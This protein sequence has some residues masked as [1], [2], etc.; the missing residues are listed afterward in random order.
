MTGH[1]IHGTSFEFESF[2]TT[3]PTCSASMMS[4]DKKPKLHRI[5]EK[6]K[7]FLTPRDEHY[8]RQF[9]RLFVDYLN[10]DE[11]LI[12]S[13]NCLY[14][15]PERKTPL[16]GRLFVSSMS[17]AFNSSSAPSRFVLPFDN[18]FRINKEQQK[19]ATKANGIR[20]V[21]DD[22]VTC[23]FG[24]FSSCDKAYSVILHQWKIKH[25][26]VDDR[27]VG[28]QMSK[29]KMNIEMG[30]NQTT[31]ESHAVPTDTASQTSHNTDDTSQSCEPANCECTDHKGHNL[32]DAI[33]PLSA[34]QMFQFLFTDN[35]NMREFLK[36]A[37]RTDVNYETWSDAGESIRKPRQ[38]KKRTSKYTVELS[39]TW[40]PKACDV[41]EQQM[42]TEFG[43]QAINGFM[44]EKEISN[45]G[46]P[47]ADAFAIELR[48]C[49]TRISPSSCR[50]RV[51]GEIVYKKAIMGMFKASNF[52][53]FIER[54]TM[55]G[56]SDYYKTLDRYL[57]EHKNSIIQKINEHHRSA[58]GRESLMST[59]ENGSYRSLAEGY[60]S[61]NEEEKS[62]DF[63]PQ[64]NSARRISTI[65]RSPIVQPTSLSTAQISLLNDISISL[66]V[67]AGILLL[68]F[69]IQLWFFFNS[70]SSPVVPESLDR[71]DS[72][73]S[74]IR[75]SNLRDLRRLLHEIEERLVA[76]ETAGR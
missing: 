27:E 39:N 1:T 72:L 67:I 3:E 60:E 49:I 38:K 58:A 63:R 11:D 46:I 36:I 68:L 8:N 29:N 59:A 7:K 42:Y 48:Y 45:S 53:G 22:G 75:H 73:A 15:D 33:Y 31:N 64:R 13:F 9:Q 71:T 21:L 25:N 23:H 24:S 37:K 28:R 61:D 66:R 18:I 30:V 6:L 35:E 69:V 70:S 47:Y 62:Q 12:A 4:L 34:N 44:M 40:G 2:A 41:T 32:L 16:T 20:I 56:M 52:L 26:A 54:Q 55:N 65:D 76:A 50:L 17:L 74:L 51:Y 57:R 5:G 14:H 43:P 19:S 10:L